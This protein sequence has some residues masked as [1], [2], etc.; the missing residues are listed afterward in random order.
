MIHRVS[1]F[2]SISIGGKIIGEWTDSR[3]KHLFLTDDF[4][5]TI[6]R[7][8]GEKIYLFSVSGK[9]LSADQLSDTEVTITFEIA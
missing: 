7:A 2:F 9:A 3:A 6:C 1:A 8:D 4:K 5:V